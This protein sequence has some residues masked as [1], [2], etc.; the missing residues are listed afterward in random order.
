MSMPPDATF[1]KALPKAEL[2]AHFSGSMSKQCLHSIW[3]QRQSKGE[4]LDLED[5]LTAIKTG[6]HGFVDVKTF[7]PLFD[8]YIYSLVDRLQWVCFAFAKVIKDFTDDGVKY[9]ELRTTPRLLHGRGKEAYVRALNEQLGGRV[10]ERPQEAENMNVFLILSIDRKMSLEQAMGVV[11]QAIA[12][13]YR[14]DDSERRNCYVVGVDLCGNP[15]VGDV[16]IFTP[17]FEKAK[18][19]GLG[20]TVH[21]AE[22]PQSA[23]NGELETILS[24]RPDR[25]G[26]C[27][28]VS[29]GWKE[30]IADS[31]IALELCLSCNVLAG[32]TTGGFDSHHFQEWH[33]RKTNPVA[34]CTD[35]VGVFGSS[36]SNE[37]LVASRT[38]DLSKQ[39]LVDLSRQAV[40][41]AF[42]GDKAK[43]RVLQTLNKF[44]T[45]HGS[46]E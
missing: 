9:L 26:H 21:F 10:R 14:P 34:L 29:P 4:L 6:E 24:W 41:A 12:Y 20:I 33:R 44:S 2:H 13:Q 27:C 7:F 25:L 43:A 17:A 8:K 5:P 15:A 31:G 42:A 40:G 39:E 11:D 32:L 22:T 19:H 30:V 23:T 35:D 3:E 37:Y 46:S 45:E 1:T 38:F 36:L 18:A 28:H 16:S